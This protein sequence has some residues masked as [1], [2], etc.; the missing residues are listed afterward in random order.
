MKNNLFI[1][2]NGYAGA[3]KDTVAKMLKILLN[4]NYNE[5]DEYK[6]YY[7]TYY[8]ND[9]QIQYATFS[10]L[11][12]DN[13]KVMTIAFADQLKQICSSMFGVPLQYFYYNKHNSWININGN[14]EFTQITPN[15]SNIVSAEE[16]YHNIDLYKN[17]HKEKYWMSLRDILVYIGTYVC[18]SDVSDNIFVNI[19]NNKINECS[20][21]NNNLEYIL[22]TDVRFVHELDYIKKHNG[23][24]INIIR[25]DVEQLDN[26]AEHDLD[27]V[28]EYDFVLENNGTYDDLLFQVWNMVHD[29]DI[30]LNKSIKLNSRYNTNN[31]IR[32]I[33]DTDNSYIWKLYTEFGALR[34]SRQDGDIQFIDPTGGP[35]INLGSNLVDN[36]YQVKSISFDNGWIIETTKN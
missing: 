4:N 23:I 15:K 17:N 3:G 25:N 13:S 29:N 8:S 24:I 31:Y 21:N 14:F 22:I 7:N 6:E 18:Q 26:I 32:L 5:F 11:D 20:Q 10:N 34:V 33:K 19:V 9:K 1:G 16:Y 30:F 35:I 36:K 28:D 12:K 2:L 27:E